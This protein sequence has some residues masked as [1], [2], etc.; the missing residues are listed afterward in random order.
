MLRQSMIYLFLS[1]I[2]VIFAAYAQLMIVYIDTFYTYVNLTLSPIF[3]RS[4]TGILI[5]SV[6][7]LV[8]IPVMLAAIPALVYRLIKGQNMPYFIHVTW[9]LWLILVLSKILI[10]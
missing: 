7:S 8:F 2:I 10:Q 5:R 1:I 4:E 3:S 6:L 9:L